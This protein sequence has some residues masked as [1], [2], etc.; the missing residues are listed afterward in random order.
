MDS[1]KNEKVPILVRCINCNYQYYENYPKGVLV[2]SDAAVCEHCGC[3]GTLSPA[4]SNVLS[5]QDG[6]L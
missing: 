1:Q 3:R 2:T 5:N 4:V 6:D